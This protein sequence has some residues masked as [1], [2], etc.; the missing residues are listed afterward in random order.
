MCA[1]CVQRLQNKATVAYYLIYDNR[2]HINSSGYL[3]AEL[4][5]P[6]VHPLGMMATPTNRTVGTP[7]QQQVTR[8]PR[9][10]IAQLCRVFVLPTT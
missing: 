6:F 2:R 4:N 7:L 1:L 10:L 3:S 9:P 5:E 8:W